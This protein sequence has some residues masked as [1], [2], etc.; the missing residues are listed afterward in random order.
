MT[1]TVDLCNNLWYMK[2]LLESL[3][4]YQKSCTHDNGRNNRC[5]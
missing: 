2:I 3:I 5:T 1:Q 4:Q